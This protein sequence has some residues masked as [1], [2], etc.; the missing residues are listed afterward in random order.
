MGIKE[1]LPFN[2]GALSTAGDLV[3]DDNLHG[4]FQPHRRNGRQGAL[5]EILVLASA[6]DRLPT[7]SAA[8]N[9]SP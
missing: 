9:M 2:G 5:A 3:F 1:D 4:Y 8:S 7:R 6:R